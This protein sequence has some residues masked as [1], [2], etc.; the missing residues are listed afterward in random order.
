MALERQE[1]KNAVGIITDVAPADLPM[2]KWSSGNNVRF[3]NGK[4]QKALG[5]QYIFGTGDFPTLTLFPFIQDKVPYWVLGAANQ[6]YT[7][8]GTTILNVSRTTGGAYNASP[9]DNWIGSSLNG[10]LV[11]NNPNDVPQAK[12]P[13]T[14]NFVNLPNWPANTTARIMRPY[15]NYLIALNVSKNSVE[16]NTLVKWS[17]PADPG[18]VPF[19]WDETDPKNDA[20]EN[21]LADTNGA[22]VDGRK[23]RD[24]FIIY[25]EDSVYS[26]R[27]IGGIY[28]FQ[29]A[30]LFDDVGMLGPNCAVEFDGKH[31]VVGNG[32]VYVHNGVQKASVIDGKMRNFLFN[33]IN[34]ENYKKTF[35]VADHLNTEMWICYSSTRVDIGS[36]CDRAIVWNWVEDTWAIRDL[37]NVS[38]GAYGII[39]PKESNLWMDDNNA[40]ESDT[41]VWGEGSYNPSKSKLLFTSFTE[42]K[43]FL[44][45]DLTTFADQP[46]L[47]SLERT[48]IYMGE[49][50]Y[51][52]TISAIIPHM[53]GNG[54]CNIYVGSA[55]VQGAGVR[56]RGPYP[57]QI[58]Y[59]YK[60]D[61]K[62]VGRYIGLKFEFPSNGNWT[63]NGY[64]VE[65]APLA[66]MR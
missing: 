19:T 21:T 52:K 29:F 11:M 54:V 4:A 63:F 17:S 16:N 10:V 51:M 40:W 24:Q 66:G 18:N 7:A 43:I 28:V 33:D 64:S 44:M 50:R 36:Y 13:N 5:Y 62:V 53:S 46:F 60:I 32:D 65:Y 12:L 23:L 25:K 56:W 6:L 3:K 41:T 35:V 59:Q 37:P 45:G 55:D 58:G 8:D 39:D 38:G 42:E 61:T 48:D 30:Q 57:Y 2:E 47:S 22:I 31:F 14:N 34:S 27:Y 49:D 26:M 9:T 20:G 15:K 1:V